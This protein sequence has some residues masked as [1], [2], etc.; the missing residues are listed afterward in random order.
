MYSVQEVA[1]LIAVELE[2]GLGDM[3]DVIDAIYEYS[4]NNTI[5]GMTNEQL[6]KLVIAELG[7]E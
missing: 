6:A 1:R 5:E 4:D 7:E 2:W 3:G